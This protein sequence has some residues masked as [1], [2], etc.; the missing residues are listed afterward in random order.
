MKP[1]KMTVAG[2][3]W[4]GLVLGCGGSSS[5]SAPKAVNAPPKGSDESKAAPPA[6]AKNPPPP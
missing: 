1:V 5:P 4:A 3:V 2:L 6:G